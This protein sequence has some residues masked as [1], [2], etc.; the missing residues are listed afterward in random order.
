MGKLW[1]KYYFHSATFIPTRQT[2]LSTPTT[3]QRVP[4]EIQKKLSTSEEKASTSLR[5]TE[6]REFYAYE[7]TTYD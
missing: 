6:T 1:G 7:T 4:I 5:K 3:Q 2:N